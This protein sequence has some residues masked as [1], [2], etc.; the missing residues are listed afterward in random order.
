MP[1]LAALR[2][3]GRAGLRW[4]RSL[5]DPQRAVR[6]AAAVALV[7]FPVLAVAG[8]RP[9]TSA[10]MGAFIAGTA[11]FQRSFR[12]RPSLAVAAGLALG[13]STLAGYLAVGVPG[14]FPV[15]LACWSFAAG[16]AWAIGPTAGVV[17][18]NTVTVML[19]VVQLPVSVPTAIGHGLLCALGGASQALVITLWPIK[20]WGA[21][22]DALADAY[23]SLADYARRLR[24]DPHATIDPE[25][26]MTARHAAALTAW[27]HRRRPPALRGL[28]GLAERVRPTLAAVADPQIGAAAE[29]PERDRV[30]ELLA[31]AAQLLDALAR[32]IRTGEPVGYPRSA[33]ASLVPPSGPV[34]HGAVLRAARRLT[35]LLGRA[36]AALEP[37]GEDTLDTPV[38]G[39]DGVLL[40]PGLAAMVPVALRTAGRQLRPGS[41]IL[42]HAVRLGGVVTAAY[43]LARLTGFQH[44]YWAAMTAAIVIRPDFVQTYSRGVARVAGTVVG[45]VLATVLVELAHPGRWLAGALAVCCIGGA[46]LLLRTGYAL[47]TTCISAYVVLLLGMEPTNPVATA[48]ER[49]LM[50]LLGGAVALLGYALFPT[51]ETARLPERTAEWITAVGRYTAA[52]LAA[53]GDPEGRDPQA[54]RGALL[55]AREAR[56]LFL[57][58][59]ERADVEPVRHGAHSPQLS[60]RQLGRAREALGSLSRVSLLMEAHL[61]GRRA[62]PVPGAGRLGQA[63]AEATAGAG[64]AVLTGRP[65][66]FRALHA[67]HRQWERELAADPWVTSAQRPGDQ[68]DVVR[69]GVRLVLQ[70]LAELPRA[71]RDVLDGDLRGAA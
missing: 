36:A 47:T 59:L 61:P 22:R 42:H 15:L 57:Q 16:L 14:L 51:W 45:V 6:G 60:R 32:A 68:A 71:V 58:T 29:G 12:P 28:R 62:D 54:V 21:Q 64:A 50:T 48:Y 20:P 52:V 31:G 4:E 70:A 8:P 39:H 46:Y 19:V 37:D 49:I 24:H 56:S 25:P 13:V 53:Y 69:S 30:R 33:P 67:V 63:L 34:L 23:A 44:G 65:A 18:A 3:T 1:W 17:A 41:P 35:A 27:Q 66:D 38:A 7:L 5:G 11:T 55:D 9:A 43:V 26:L 40:R 2:H 10:A